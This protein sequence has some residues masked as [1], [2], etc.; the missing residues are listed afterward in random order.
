MRILVAIGCRGTSGAAIVAACDILSTS[1][2]GT[3]DV[4]SASAGI[5]CDVVA[6]VGE[7]DVSAGVDDSRVESWVGGD[8]GVPKVFIFGN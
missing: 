4:V 2:G 6:A 5:A 8:G 7:A 3:H 1:I